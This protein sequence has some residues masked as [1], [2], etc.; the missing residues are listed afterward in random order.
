MRISDWSSDVCSSDLGAIELGARGF[1]DNGMIF[2]ARQ[3]AERK[4]FLPNLLRGPNR[5]GQYGI[6]FGQGRR[7]AAMLGF[8]DYMQAHAYQKRPRGLD[9]KSVVWERVC[10]YV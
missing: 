10:R 7:V 3:M 5:I 6:H 2:A 1:A 9:R 8:V 4:H